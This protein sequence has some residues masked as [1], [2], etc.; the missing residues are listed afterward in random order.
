ML[1][2]IQGIEITL[3]DVKD[4][5]EIIFAV[6]GTS[7]AFLAYRAAKKTV[8]SPLKT[9]V[10]KLQ[11]EAIKEVHQYIAVDDPKIQSIDDLLDIWPMWI[12]NVKYLYATWFLV[13][14]RA[15]IE[16]GDP[17]EF[18]EEQLLGV[19]SELDIQNLSFTSCSANRNDAITVENWAYMS[20][21]L[22]DWM[23]AKVKGAFLTDKFKKYSM[24]CLVF[25]HSPWL[26]KDLLKLLEE[27]DEAL[28]TI[29]EGIQKGLELIKTAVLNE[30][31]F[32]SSQKAA[33]FY[34]FQS[35][36]WELYNSLDLDAPHKKIVEIHDYIREYLKVNNLMD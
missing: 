6:V 1:E 11:I 36:H 4:V 31:T 28:A 20:H 32:D 7:I 8:L 33:N 15:H 17:H 23:K 2:W 27:Y 18:S 24:G 5:S 26:P 21:T 29:P 14:S 34:S 25:Y 9:E 19:R 30:A 35:T 16:A 10:L 3:S 22:A 13:Y 12:L